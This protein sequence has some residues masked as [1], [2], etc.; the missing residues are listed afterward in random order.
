MSDLEQPNL[1]NDNQDTRDSAT[2]AIISP[3]TESNENGGAANEQGDSG[4]PKEE[5]TEDKNRINLKVVDG[6]GGEIFFKVKRTTPMKKIMSAY[7]VKQGRAEDSVRFFFDGNRV[8]AT[9]TPDDL[10][11]EDNDV[12][13]VHHAQLGGFCV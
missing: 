5:K 12:V 9:Q 11:M 4:Q 6:N 8:N 10:D 13:E 7:C 2:P 3:P 1:P